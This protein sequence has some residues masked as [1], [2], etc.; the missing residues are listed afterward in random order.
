MSVL[1]LTPAGSG[2]APRRLPRGP[3][4]LQV[5]VSVLVPVL[6]L[7]VYLF[8]VRQ[9]RVAASPAPSPI[10][11]P[12][13]PPKSNGT[14]TPKKRKGAAD[15]AAAALVRTAIRGRVNHRK[16]ALAIIRATPP[17]MTYGPFTS[18]A[19]QTQMTLTG[20]ARDLSQVQVAVKQFKRQK[21]VFS[22]AKLT[23]SAAQ[24]AT[25]TFAIE[26]TI[27]RTPDQ[28]AAAGGSAS[29]SAAPGA[30]PP[31]AATPTP[32]TPTPPAS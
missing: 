19:A 15:P 26:L 29:E 18:D 17:G 16:L 21:D 12:Q 24:G 22:S 25:A 13:T 7:G 8:L 28:Q 9:N 6:A 3:Q 4:G 11:Q 27:K 2:A 14:A 1:N 10:A 32:A 31:A 20:T 30:T 23:Q 5:I